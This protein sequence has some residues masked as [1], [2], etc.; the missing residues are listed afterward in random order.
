MSFN[1]VRFLKKKCV[2]SVS[3][4]LAVV[5]NDIYVLVRRS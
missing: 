5:Y 3:T 4:V 2:I 1:N